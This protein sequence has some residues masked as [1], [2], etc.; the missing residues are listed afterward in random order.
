MKELK[1]EISIY[2]LLPC[3]HIYF[4]IS[5]ISLPLTLKKY[6]PSWME[7]KNNNFS[8]CFAMSWEEEKKLFFML[9]RSSHAFHIKIHSAIQR[10]K[11]FYSCYIIFLLILS[12]FLF[13]LHWLFYYYYY[14][15]KIKYSLIIYCRYEYLCMFFLN[16]ADHEWKCAK[17][18]KWKKTNRLGFFFYCDGMLGKAL[19][20]C[21]FVFSIL[22]E[23]K[24]T[25][26]LNS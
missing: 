14:F 25:S 2:F 4:L 7:R 16:Y 20:T 18:R 23:N 11:N 13:L 8:V 19:S 6:E 12:S 1:E 3:I 9:F 22:L 15:M 10:K 5:F 17:E 24:F 21:A 26:I